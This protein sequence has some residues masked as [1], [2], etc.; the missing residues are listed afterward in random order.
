MEPR[1]RLERAHDLAV[2]ALLGDTIY[3][4]G[5]LVIILFPICG[6][7]LLKFSFF[8]SSCTQYWRLSRAHPFPGSKISFSPSMKET[9]ESSRVYPLSCHKRSATYAYTQFP[10][11]NILTDFSFQP[12]LA[13]NVAFLRQKICLMALIEAVF[14]RNADERTMTFQTIAEETR[15]PQEEVEHLVMKALRYDI[16]GGSASS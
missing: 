1:E 11:S 15:L 5:E 12:I 10:R 9:S 2:S 3:N 16:R 6:A 7:S 13:A 8:F 4:F 14:S